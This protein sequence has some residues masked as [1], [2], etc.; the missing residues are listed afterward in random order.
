M[1][2]KFIEKN[3]EYLLKNLHLIIEKEFFHEYDDYLLKLYTHLSEEEK[4]LYKEQKKNEMIKKRDF[5][6]LYMKE[7]EKQPHKPEEVLR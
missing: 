2:E 7:Q 4:K 6:I 5:E 3:E 1:K